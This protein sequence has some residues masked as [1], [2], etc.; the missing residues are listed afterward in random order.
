MPGECTETSRASVRIRDFVDPSR[1]WTKP[2]AAGGIVCPAAHLFGPRADAARHCRNGVLSDLRRKTKWHR[3]SNE[4]KDVG[5]II[6]ECISLLNDPCIPSGRSLSA[7]PARRGYRVGPDNVLPC[8]ESCALEGMRAGGT[9]SGSVFRL[10]GTSTAAPQLGRQVV[11]L[12][13]GL[14][15][16]TPTEVPSLNDVMEIEKRGGGNIE[17]P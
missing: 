10:T 16:P 1:G 11:R 9:R 8:D 12:A 2:I 13:S 17:P 6:I 15:F 4:S 14:P 5:A 3:S 7:G